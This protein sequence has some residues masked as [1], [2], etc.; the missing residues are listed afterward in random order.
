MP[1]LLKADYDVRC[2]V[3]PSSDTGN[4]GS[5]VELILGDLNDRR[6]L[7]RALRGVETLVNIASLGFGH[8]PNIVDAAS[9]SGVCRALFISTTA[10]FTGLNARSKTVRLAA[11][12]AIG[13]SGLKY[14]ILRP[15]M[16]YGGARDRNL[17]RLVRYLKRCPIL[18]IFGDGSHLQ[19]PVHVE[20][21]ANAIVQCLPEEKTIGKSYN[22]SGGSALSFND[23][24]DTICRLMNRKVWKLHIPVAPVVATLSAVERLSTRL[25][26]KA[27]QV[28]RLDE[29]KSFDHSEAT[30]DFGYQ[31]RS[32]E[33]GILVE[34]ETLGL[35]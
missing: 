8:C 9:N 27:E 26:I 7:E 16:I 1:L 2:L 12:V 30:R 3:R 22:I 31:P 33:E 35:L 21:V 11:E 24:V 18:P 25:P 15:T 17:C 29:H 14:T 13:K 20:D 28:L 6:S 4:L 5:K 32:F 23:L 19:Q 34:L 10:V